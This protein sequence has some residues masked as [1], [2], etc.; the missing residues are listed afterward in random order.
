MINKKIMP[1]MYSV[2]YMVVAKKISIPV[3]NA[4]TIL[5]VHSCMACPIKEVS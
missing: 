5:V 4:F 3:H 1:P 2:K